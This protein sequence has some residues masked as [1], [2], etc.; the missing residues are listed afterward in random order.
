MHFLF[1]TEDKNSLFDIVGR[2]AL[3]KLTSDGKPFF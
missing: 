3:N 1:L 2:E